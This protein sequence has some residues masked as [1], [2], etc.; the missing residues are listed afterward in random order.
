VLNMTVWVWGALYLF[1]VVV[2]LPVINKSHK[3]AGT[4]DVYGMIA[5]VILIMIW[6]VVF[7]AIVAGVIRA[8]IRKVFN[9]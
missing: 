7:A 4:S 8:V 3:Q 2:H 1:G 9:S 5:I 6:P